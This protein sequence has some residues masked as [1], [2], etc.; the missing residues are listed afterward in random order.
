MIIHDAFAQPRVA[1]EAISSGRAMSQFQAS[2]QAS[3][4]SS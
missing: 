3:T 1:M 4:I 2:Q